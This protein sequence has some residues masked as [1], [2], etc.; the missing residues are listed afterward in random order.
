MVVEVIAIDIQ[1]IG[2]HQGATEAHQ[3]SEAGEAGAAVQASLGALFA[4]ATVV[5]LQ[6]I[7]QFAADLL[8]G[9][10]VI[11]C[12]VLLKGEDHIQGAGAGPPGLPV[13]HNPPLGMQAKVIQ[14]HHQAVLLRRLGWF[15]MEMGRRILFVIKIMDC[16]DCVS[17][18]PDFYCLPS[19][20][21]IHSARSVC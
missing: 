9:D 20:V 2:D 13:V 3:G 11:L 4:I 21:W 1:V 16:M 7:V 15:P 14:G 6:A 17:S 10:T 12:H 8:S 5:I 19:S 18:E